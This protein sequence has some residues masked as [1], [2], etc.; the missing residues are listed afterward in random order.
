MPNIQ[1]QQFINL[2]LL[3]TLGYFSANIY[4]SVYAIGTLFL[5]T[6]LLEYIFNIPKKIK[7]SY[8]S[9]SSFITAIGLILMMVSTQY[10]VYLIVLTLALAQKYFLRLKSGHIFNPS[11]FALIM[12]LLFFY[13]KAHIVLGQLGDEIW[14][15]A[16]MLSFGIIILWQ[17]KRWI[18][19]A[20]FILSYFGFQ[21]ICIVT[22]DP[23]ILFE[24]VYARFYSISFIVFILFMLT[25]PMTTPSQKW[26]Q[27]LFALGISLMA[28]F[29]DYGYGFRVQHLFLSL[30][31]ISSLYALFFKNKL[32]SMKEKTI[33]GVLII[34]V[35]S[36]IIFIQNQEPY[37]FE[38][39]G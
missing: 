15:M 7:R 12:A 18:I 24:D 23:L 27:V 17:A 32:S 14:L 31:M 34:L 21:Y 28:T 25:D 26:E 37:Y 5:V 13:D 39:D 19:S 6:F 3:L 30:F 36:V 16:L 1:L 20:F 8:F 9:F 2:L 10:W 11:N 38:M 4:L 33:A 35:L 22:L 29:M